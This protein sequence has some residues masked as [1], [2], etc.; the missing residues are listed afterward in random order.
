MKSSIILSFFIFGLTLTTLIP[1]DRV[2]IKFNNDV[3]NSKF[4]EV[5]LKSNNLSDSNYLKLI[6]DFVRSRTYVLKHLTDSSV[7]SNKESELHNSEL[8]IPY[9]SIYEVSLDSLKHP[10]AYNFFKSQNLSITNATGDDLI[11]FR[12]YKHIY[13]NILHYKKLDYFENIKLISQ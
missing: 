10:I 7:Y 6:N 1:F 2:P 8:P 5:R 12:F 11:K 13:E 9:Q 3:L 4:I